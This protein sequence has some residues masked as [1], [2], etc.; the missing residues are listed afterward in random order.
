MTGVKRPSFA[1]TLVFSRGAGILEEKN[2]LEN[3]V[4]NRMENTIEGRET[5]RLSSIRA[6]MRTAQLTAEKAMDMLAIPKAKQGHYKAL[7]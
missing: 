5:E 6:L 7:L 3:F 4:G 2:F 1:E